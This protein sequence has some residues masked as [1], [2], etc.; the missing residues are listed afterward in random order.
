MEIQFAS[1]YMGVLY[2]NQGAWT[3]QGEMME[4]GEIFSQCCNYMVGGRVSVSRQRLHGCQAKQI[5]IQKQ[6]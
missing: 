4:T 2:G 3:V 1:I 5:K 6:N